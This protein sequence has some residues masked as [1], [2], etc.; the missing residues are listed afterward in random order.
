MI[1][2]G[3]F[4]KIKT[5]IKTKLKYYQRIKKP[6]LKIFLSKTI[7]LAKIRKIK[8]MIKFLIFLRM[9]KF[10]VSKKIL[11]N[12]LNRLLKLIF[13]KNKNNKI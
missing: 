13:S 5:S 3:K 6:K 7:N 10:L 2:Q 9:I 4:N 12:N 1:K 8:D 11:Y